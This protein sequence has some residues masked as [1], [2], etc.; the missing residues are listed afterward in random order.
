MRCVK[1]EKY[2]RLIQYHLCT[3][4]CR[5]GR[6]GGRAETNTVRF[7]VKSDKVRRSL[8]VLY[9]IHVINFIIFVF[10]CP[11]GFTSRIQQL[12]AITGTML[13]V[14]LAVTLVNSVSASVT[15]WSRRYTPSLVRVSV[16]PGRCRLYLRPSMGITRAGHTTPGW[17][18]FVATSPLPCDE[19]KSPEWT[20][21]K[22]STRWKWN[23]TTSITCCDIVL[24]FCENLCCSYCFDRLRVHISIGLP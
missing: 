4:S 7:A 12:P 15:P 3:C 8:S 18:I 5:R 22:C 14:G 1:G 6:G 16:M 13:V 17:R 2:F 23:W 10:P 19:I 21:L 11:A 20:K 24:D 9:V